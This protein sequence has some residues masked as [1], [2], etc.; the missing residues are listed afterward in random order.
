MSLGVFEI[1]HNSL[2][3][4]GSPWRLG[5]LKSCKLQLSGQCFSLLMWPVFIENFNW[6]FLRNNAG[7]EVQLIILFLHQFFTI[8]HILGCIRK[9]ENTAP[10][11]N[12]DLVNVAN[13]HCVIKF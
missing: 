7:G 6:E 8:I 4:F 9:L 12:L 2:G 5:V 11:T 10:G 13:T 3:L 1:K